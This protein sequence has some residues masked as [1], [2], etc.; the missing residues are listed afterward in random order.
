MKTALDLQRSQGVAA[1]TQDLFLR[2]LHLSR[3]GFRLIVEA[4]QMQK[5]M[6]DIETKLPGERG[7]KRMSMA[8]RRFNADKNL[9]M[10]KRKN[11]GWT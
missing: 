9:T 7:P 5:P 8:F 6:N 1:G 2:S 11:V 3:A 10:L 4:M